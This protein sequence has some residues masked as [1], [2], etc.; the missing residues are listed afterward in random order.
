[1]NVTTYVV[2]PHK[3]LERHEELT[4]SLDALFRRYRIPPAILQYSFVDRRPCMRYT[5][6]LNLLSPFPTPP[7]SELLQDIGRTISPLQSRFV[8]LQSS[9]YPPVLPPVPTGVY[10][11]NEDRFILTRSAPKL[12]YGPNISCGSGD[13]KTMFESRLRLH[14]GSASE[15]HS[16]LRGSFSL[17][18]RIVLLPSWH[19]LVLLNVPGVW[20]N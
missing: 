10:A 6:T 18:V 3:Q 15:T 20:S 4:R 5:E 8:G 12:L 19:S 13:S 1:M 2:A 9:Y 16:T 17:K 11:P 14:Y 7:S